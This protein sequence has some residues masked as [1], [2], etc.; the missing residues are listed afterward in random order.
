[1]GFS[2]S[3]TGPI[4]L[5]GAMLPMAIAVEAATQEDEIK[6]LLSDMEHKGATQEEDLPSDKEHLGVCGDR[7]GATNA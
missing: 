6:D 4:A 7:F 5:A 1:M 2:D 3:L